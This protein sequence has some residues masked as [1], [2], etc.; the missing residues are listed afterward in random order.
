MG[1]QS[2]HPVAD[3]KRE[4]LAQCENRLHD[5]AWVRTM[6]C[7]TFELWVC[8]PVERV[9]VQMPI[10]YV[11]DKESINLHTRRRENLLPVSVIVR[12]MSLQ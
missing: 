5:D 2:H 4:A 9:H 6:A 8:N 3:G 12:T 10:Q 1:L 7:G 11:G